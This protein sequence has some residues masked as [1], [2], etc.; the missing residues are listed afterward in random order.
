MKGQHLVF[1]AILVLLASSAWG[2]TTTPGAGYTDKEYTG[3]LHCNGMTDVAWT[4]AVQKLI[5][6][7]LEDAKNVMMG[8]SKVEWKSCPAVRRPR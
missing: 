8:A 4:T 3:L 5:G 6:V 2:Q 1:V 7:S